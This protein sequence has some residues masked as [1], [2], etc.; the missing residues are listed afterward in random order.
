MDQNGLWV[1][2]DSKLSEKHRR[3][4]EGNLEF[5]RNRRSLRR[6]RPSPGSLGFLVRGVSGVLDDGRIRVVR[7]FAPTR[8]GNLLQA[9][10]IH[11][12]IS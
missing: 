3:K 2:S 11:S 8:R 5:F 9:L 12:D 4:K 10:R 7:V 6:C 1:G